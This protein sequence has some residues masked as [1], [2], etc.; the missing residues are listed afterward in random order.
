MFHTLHRRRTECGGSLLA[1]QTSSWVWS[2]PG[3]LSSTSSLTAQL[4]RVSFIPLHSQET[5]AGD[6]RLPT[7]Y[8]PPHLRIS[9]PAAHEQLDL[10]ASLA[11]SSAECPCLEAAAGTGEKQLA[12]ALAA[13]CGTLQQ[14]VASGPC[15]AADLET[16]LVAA[17]VLPRESTAPRELGEGDAGVLAC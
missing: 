8:P 2:V 6:G 11:S 3:C 15:T 12:D 9:M 5:R 4:A 7:S 13:A 14:D 1:C 16:A 10:V 17:S